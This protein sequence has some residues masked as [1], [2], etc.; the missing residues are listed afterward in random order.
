VLDQLKDFQPDIVC[1]HSLGSLISYDT[2][3]RP[4]NRRLVADRTLITFGSQIGNPFVRNALGGRLTN[5][6]G[7]KSWYHLFNVHDKCLHARIRLNDPK[8]FPW[9]RISTSPAFSITRRSNIFRI[10][11]P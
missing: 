5:L 10:R 9:K 8:F 2:F 1:A 7:D 6:V 11:T 4:E 3:V